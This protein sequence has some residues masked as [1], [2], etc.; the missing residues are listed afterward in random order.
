MVLYV[1][2]PHK[3]GA[4][5]KLD[6]HCHTK[7]GSLDGK[8]SLEEYV[9]I[10]KEKGYGGMVIT[11]HNS[12]NAYRYYKKHKTEDAFQNFVV[13]KGIEYDT[14]D[15]G[16]ILVIMPEHV[17]LPLLELRGLPVTM[18]I[19]LVHRFGGILGPAHPCG[20][21]YLSIT[22]TK[23]F[24]NNPGVIRGFDFI[25]TFNAC[26]SPESNHLAA[27]LAAAYGLPGFGGSD[28]H[29]T[30][31]AGLAYAEID[32]DITCESELIHAVKA[33]AAVKSG[34]AY[35]HGTTKERIG[36][37]NNLLVYSFWVYNKTAGFMRYYKRRLAL[38]SYSN[39]ARHS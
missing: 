1:R 35:Y 10:L 39:L 6:M 31:C 7:E 12:Y 30:E 13:L 21:K 37:V 34:G 16:H 15:A 3:M 27:E 29:K 2:W 4:S 19:D 32:A 8:I 33:G 14:I 9:T 24:R 18:L 38:T 25:E 17:K 28:A 36:K 11:D 22:N 5:M 26:E 23:H 20:E